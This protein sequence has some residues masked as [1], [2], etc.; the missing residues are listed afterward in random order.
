M[1]GLKNFSINEARNAIFGYSN[2]ELFPSKDSESLSVSGTLL[3][4]TI[5]SQYFIN[6]YVNMII[7]VHLVQSSNLTLLPI[8]YVK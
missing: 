7:Y 6:I 5:S 8:S 3:S 4:T 1:R 2:S